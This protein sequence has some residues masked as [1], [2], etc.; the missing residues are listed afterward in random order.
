MSESLIVLASAAKNID[1]REFAH[2]KEDAHVRIS[3][4]IH[5]L[6]FLELGA[7]K[8]IFVRESIGSIK[9]DFLI[10]LDLV[11]ERF[12][13]DVLKICVDSSAKEDF[14]IIE[15]SGKHEIIGRVWELVIKMRCLELLRV[16]K[17]DII[18]LVLGIALDCTASRRNCLE[19]E[20]L[21]VKGNYLALVCRLS[22]QINFS[23]LYLW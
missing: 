23:L 8:I 22:E 1:I 7:E 21:Q 15:I 11:D 10:V 20:F 13:T 19:L 3:F 16:L 17:D 9:W 4:L 18:G 12:L 2:G 6:E 14:L 5:V